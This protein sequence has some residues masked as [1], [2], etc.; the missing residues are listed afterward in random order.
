MFD[1][2]GEL[3]GCLLCIFLLSLSTV[4]CAKLAVRFQDN[5]RVVRFI[6]FGVWILVADQTGQGMLALSGA[7]RGQPKAEAE[8]GFHYLT[9]SM[10][11]TFKNWHLYWPRNPQ[12]GQFWLN[13]ASETG[14]AAAEAALAQAYIDGDMG[15]PKDGL[16]ASLYLKKILDNQKVD[17][18]TKA[19][20]AFNLYQLYKEGE[21]VPKDDV[22]ALSYC[23]IASDSG[24]AEASMTL[25]KAYE[26]GE[27]IEPDYGKA[28]AYYQTAVNNGNLGAVAELTRLKAQ[29]GQNSGKKDADDD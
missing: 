12:R 15:L 16:Q 22:V 3:F 17:Q 24:N 13:K 26:A 18:D 7:V 27:V 11:G 8:L 9:G 19:E 1:Q 29:L 6:L 23:A 21:G 10:M 2:I 14:N 4:L 5:L 20:A 28:Y 25:A